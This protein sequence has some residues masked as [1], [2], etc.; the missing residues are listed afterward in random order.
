L[1][2]NFK[3]KK[4]ESQHN[5]IRNLRFSLHSCK[6]KLKCQLNQILK[7]T[8]TAA[9][10]N[11]VCGQMYY[12]LANVEKRD[13]ISLKLSCRKSSQSNSPRKWRSDRI[14]ANYIHS[15]FLYQNLKVAAAHLIRQTHAYINKWINE[16]CVALLG[17]IKTHD[18]NKNRW[19]NK[20]MYTRAMHFNHVIHI[21]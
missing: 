7:R 21:I 10:C 6:Q 19:E 15:A 2:S 20:E 9:V 1:Q 3:V 17:C 4:I 13:Q 16:R 12:C 5:Q 18:A 11:L 8:Q 14:K